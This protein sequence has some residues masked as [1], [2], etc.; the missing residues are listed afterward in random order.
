MS[1]KTISPTVTDESMD[2]SPNWETDPS[3]TSIHGHR[4]DG[5]TIAIHSLSV[6]PAYQRRGLGKTIMKSYN[7]R[8]ETSGV[9]D[10]IALLA[11]DHLVGMYESMGFEKK[12]KS[13][14]RFAGGGW[15][16]LTYEF[17]EY[18]PGS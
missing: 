2:V 4:E 16:S 5:R 14:V 18:N 9:A 15:N 17:A 7:Q 11:H 12:G 13:D 6:L 8:M 10:R 1:T 3:N